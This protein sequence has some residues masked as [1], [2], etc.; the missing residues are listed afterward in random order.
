MREVILNNS[1]S[2]D[3]RFFFNNHKN[4]C[5]QGGAMQNPKLNSQFQFLKRSLKFWSL[6]FNKTRSQKW[7]KSFLH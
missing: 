1:L 2:G 6:E 7:V 4:F 5:K 3:Y